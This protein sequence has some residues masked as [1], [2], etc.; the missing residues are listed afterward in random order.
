MDKRYSQ[1]QL[2]NV[3]GTISRNLY[4]KTRSKDVFL[5]SDKT[6]KSY[7][8]TLDT[9]FGADL[10]K[11]ITTNELKSDLSDQLTGKY[12]AD[13]K[14]GFTLNKRIT[15]VVN[16]LGDNITLS[17]SGTTLTITINPRISL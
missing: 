1:I 7:L 12:A 8:D 13:A 17:L 5:A 6:L 14:I 11:V 9:K 2:I 3:N 10:S 4:P 16:A 15:D